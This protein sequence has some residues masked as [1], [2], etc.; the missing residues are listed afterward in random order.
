M[1]G[2]LTLAIDFGT[3]NTVAVA[4][5]DGA[6]PRVV[7]V[8]GAPHLPS[9]VLREPDGRLVVG[10]DA[11]RLGRTAAHRLE[12]RPKS[13]LDEDTLLLGDATVGVLDVVRAVL[14]RVC[15]E[16]ARQADRPV[17][18][19]V[20]THPADWGALRMGRLPQAAAGLAARQ[21]LVPEPVA[22]AAR[23]GLPDGAAVLVL[24]LGGGTCDAAVVRREG[25]G[26]AVL[27][28]AGLPDLGGDDL[29]QRIIDGI[30]AAHPEATDLDPSSRDPKT[31]RAVL[32]LRQDA[33]A[34]KE[35]LSRHESAKLTV[36]GVAE[37]VTLTRAA[38]EE[39]V[40]PDLRRVVALA[41]RVLTESGAA[42]GP[43][44]NVDGS[45]VRGVHLVGGTSRIPRLATLLGEELGLPVRADPEPEAGVAWGAIELAAA[46]AS[47]APT[48]PN[49]RQSPAPITP[50]PPPVVPSGRSGGRRWVAGVAAAVAV[51]LV[52]TVAVFAGQRIGGQPRAA[53]SAPTSLPTGP[54]SSAPSG[55]PSAQPDGPVFP[56]VRPGTAVVN[57]DAP[58]PIVV[59]LGQTGL[60]RS[61][62]TY[63]GATEVQE[64]VRLERGEVAD[65][66]A[67][68]GY[69]WV[70]G[71]I[72][73]T[74]RVGEGLPSGDGHR[75]FL[76]DD[77]GQWIES[78]NRAGEVTVALC[79]SN[80]QDLPE[81]PVGKPRT[82]CAAFLVPV[83]TGV[84]GVLFDDRGD[85]PTGVNALLFPLDLPPA[86][87]ATLPAGEGR[88]GG[89]AV[90]VPADD[91]FARI[92]IAHLLKE[93]SAYLVDPKPKPGRRVYLLRFAIT[94]SGVGSVSVLT[95]T[96]GLFL[97]D[98]R[99]L[100][101]GRAY[102]D[103]QHCKQQ[104]EYDAE[105]V[106]S[107]NSLVMCLAFDM[108][109]Q[110]TVTRI[111][112]QPGR[113]TDPTTW[114]AWQ[115]D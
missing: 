7:S 51:A 77:R 114:V 79:G 90:E 99:G 33:R 36:P 64:E 13:R 83:A 45:A 73:T 4:T 58:D 84:R 12:T 82:E 104:D 14:A 2:E 48:T 50:G 25:A 49:T 112:Y 106:P 47:T 102:Y 72:V 6:A 69:R 62:G 32:L 39:L 94:A 18:H 23:T 105:R 60:F 113:D 98:E 61:K 21:S 10:T 29:D 54:A 115:L 15:A 65:R 16:A 30:R 1:T 63:E 81:T 107:G 87:K 100:P 41:R 92:T 52:V 70:S 89:Q 11:L 93:P 3:T 56:P 67:P 85:D 42:P 68:P 53:G 108:A 8:D 57:I 86:G 110:A 76:L 43:N 71:T 97:L 40:E 9:A 34:A 26:Y 17:G 55:E 46:T 19:L 74:M 24:D 59:P 27:S 96:D 38:F 95:I 101:V 78:V 75:V 111:V 31:M 109:R 91:G 37:P 88:V 20:L 28:C 44:V 103:I 35:V 80:Q 66:P 22:V 5:R